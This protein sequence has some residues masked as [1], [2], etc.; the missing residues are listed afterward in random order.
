MKFGDESKYHFNGRWVERYWRV[1]LA[2]MS[3]QTPPLMQEGIS[4]HTAASRPLLVLCSRQLYEL[5]STLEN[6]C[7]DGPV[8][9][10]L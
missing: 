5:P 9:T 1:T 6:G 7:L 2:K 4:H 8:G 10:S 3:P